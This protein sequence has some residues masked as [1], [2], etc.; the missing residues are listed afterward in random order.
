MEF[1]FNQFDIVLSII[2]LIL[3]IRGAFKGF[4]AEI[5]SMAAIILGIGS[6]VIFSGLLSNLIVEIF[7]ESIWSPVIAFLAIFIIVYLV[8]KLLEGAIH[9][10]IEKLNLHRLDKV[11]GFLLGLIEGILIVSCLVFIVRIQPFFE[12]AHKMLETSF[13]AN[14]ILPILMPTAV[15]LLLENE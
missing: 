5:L 13:Y 1:N 15:G 8:V 7:G 4:V 2:I 14:I 3:M 6:S 9:K 10:G 11:M 12:D